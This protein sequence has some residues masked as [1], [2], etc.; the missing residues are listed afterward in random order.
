MCVI[1]NDG[2]K[3]AMRTDSEL[4]LAWNEMQTGIV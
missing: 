1:D 3:V 2:D 4:Q